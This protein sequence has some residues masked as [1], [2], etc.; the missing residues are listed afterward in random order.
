M[1]SNGMF[2]EHQPAWKSLRSRLG[3][4]VAD[5]NWPDPTQTLHAV[6]TCSSEIPQ[7]FQF[8]HPFHKYGGRKAHAVAT[9]NAALYTCQ[10]EHF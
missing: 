7:T 9:V 3:R 10:W 2:T 8:V 6:P 1:K 4:Q 5:N